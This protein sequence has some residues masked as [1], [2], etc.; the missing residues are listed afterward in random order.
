MYQI[1][2][3]TM[4]VILESKQK[5]AIIGDGIDLVLIL[6]SLIYGFV[7]ENIQRCITDSEMHY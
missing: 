7:S 6:L 2:N 4:I 1:A 3:K 5:K